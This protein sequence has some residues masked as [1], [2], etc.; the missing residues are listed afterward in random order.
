MILLKKKKTVVYCLLQVRLHKR[1]ILGPGAGGSTVFLFPL[2]SDF[3]FNYFQ[4]ASSLWVPINTA[5]TISEVV[6]N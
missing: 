5:F 1:Q 3:F 6:K 2:V 4:N